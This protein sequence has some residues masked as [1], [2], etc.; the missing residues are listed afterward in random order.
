MPPLRRTRPPSTAAQ[1]LLLKHLAAMRADFVRT[2]MRD[3]DITGLSNT[4]EVMVDLVR[5]ALRD[6]EL[7]WDTVIAFLDAHEPNGKQRV[8]M[9]K[10][11]EAQRQ[12]Y[13]ADALKASLEDGGLG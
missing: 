8:L 2:L 5:K 6:G 7:S 1:E 9:F 3:N 10:A 4:K 12:L 11:T 13:S